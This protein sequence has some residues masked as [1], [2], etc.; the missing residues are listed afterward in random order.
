[1]STVRETLA[2]MRSELIGLVGIFGEVVI[3]AGAGFRF[4]AHSDAMGCRSEITTRDSN[5]LFAT[6]VAC[7]NHSDGPVEDIE[8]VDGVFSMGNARED[9]L[10]IGIFR[11]TFI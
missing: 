2:D 1:M 11:S 5:W 10:P 9:E 8:M 7:H 6:C 3:G 4:E